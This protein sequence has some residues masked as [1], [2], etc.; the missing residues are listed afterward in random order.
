MNP[1]ARLGIFTVVLTLVLA[2]FTWP[3][4]RLAPHD[5]PLGVVGAPPAALANEGFELHTYGSEADARAAIM[6][7]EVYGA[8]AG[9]TAL[10]ATGASPA[11][12]AAIRQAA[13]Q[14]RVV[15]LAPGTK[16]D[17]RV[18]TLSALALPLTLLGIATALMAFLTAGGVAGRAGLILAGGAITGVVAAL[19]TQ[20]WLDALPGS[21]L[22]IAGVA[23][24]AVVAVAAPVAGLAG[25]LGPPGIGIGALLMMVVANPWSGVASAPELLPEPIGVIGQWLPTGAA[26]SA[27]RS[28]AYFDGAAVG[29]PLVVL[30]AWAVAGLALVA[31]GRARAGARQPSARSGVSI[32]TA[33]SSAGAG[34]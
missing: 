32:R 7:R 23:G 34:R 31:A 10:V 8:L 14:A 5:L 11:V 29:G 24:L 1:I 17:P 30:A 21:W 33:R 15:D 25:R 20:T 3:A 18:A 16:R 12:A 28:V 4:G 6:D 13:P 9:R 2:A 26:G 27:L 22:G 19:L